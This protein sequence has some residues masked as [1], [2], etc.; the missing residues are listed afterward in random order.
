ML[1]ALVPKKPLLAR[2][3]GPPGRGS[4]SRG[5]EIWRCGCGATTTLD[6]K[7]EG[8]VVPVAWVSMSIW[9]GGAGEYGLT[10]MEDKILCPLCAYNHGLVKTP[11]APIG[12]M[13]MLPP[14]RK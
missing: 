9:I 5:P 10:K 7:Q 4:R 2:P 11:L 14:K 12:P 6:S 3:L 13:K 8:N 1:D